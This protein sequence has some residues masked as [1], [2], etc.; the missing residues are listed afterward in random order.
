MA[1][2]DGEQLMLYKDLGMIST[3]LDERRLPSLRGPLAIAHC[4]YSTTGS[5]IW[6]NAQPTYRQ[7]PR[8]A[9][10]IGHNGN[11]V[12]TRELLDPARGRPI[13]PAG[14]DRH[15]AADRAARRRA[16]R[17]HGR[18]ARPGPAARPWRVQPGHPRRAPGHRR[19]RPARV[20]AAG[21]G[22]HPGRVAAARRPADGGLWSR[23]SRQRTGWC[24]SS[25]TASLDIVGAEFVRDVEPGE[26]VVLEPGRAP[27]SVRYAEPN[28]ALCVFE[29]IYFA[30]PDSYMEGRNLY[31]ARRR[32]GEQLAVEHPVDADLV[33]PVPDTGAPA[34]AGYRGG[35]RPAVPRGDVPQPVR[36]T[37]V[38]PAVAGPPPPGRDDQAQPD[39]RG[40]GR[41]AARSWSTTRSCAARRPSASSSCCARPAR[42]RGPRPDQ[43]PADLPPV[44]LRHRH[45]HRDRADRLDPHARRRSASSSAP[46]RWATSR[47]AACWPRSTCRTTGSASPASTAT[48][49]SPCR[50]T[51]HRA[52]SCSK[53]R[54]WPD[55]ATRPRTAYRRSG[56]DV[57][58]GE[59]AVDLM[60]A[61]VESTRRPEVVGG[62]GGFGGGVH[63]PGRATASRCSSP[64]PT[65][66]APRRRSPS[67]VG[68]FD[69]IGIDLVAMCADD[70]VCTGAEPLAFL[71]YVA[72]GRLDP[73]A[74]PSSSASVAA[75]CRERRRAPSSAARPPSTRDCSRRTSSTSPA[76][77]S[78]SSSA[79]G[80]STASRIEAGDVILGLASS[81][82]HAN[83][84]SLVRSLIA[85]WDLD[86]AEPYQVR[87][88]RTLGDAETD[89]LLAVAPQRGDGRPSARCC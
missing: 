69:T 85:Q 38:H 49:R 57:D 88:R 24:L 27:R 75:G 43:R 62:L 53:S 2:S 81:G 83:G 54:S 8:R 28:P 68:R 44:L 52:S 10:A 80:S 66:S 12:N 65:A 16:R 7:G 67:A 25:E 13:A 26:I 31:E 5:T 50:T 6:E 34:A 20:P 72:V 78:A 19:A 87:L 1:V 56:V 47:S 21:P 86:L 36:R 32:M 84:Y 39:A 14:L 3:V 37:D 22:P 51:P 33:I 48:T 11:L 15:R 42:S 59:R 79:R 9:I 29:L 55:D 23:D 30:R 40:R 77:A 76:A 41:Q 58:A 61:H 64:R 45:L 74:S 4:R 82:L 17:R 89:R 63:D 70:V 35:E 60:R 71:D 46:I 18:G 73:A